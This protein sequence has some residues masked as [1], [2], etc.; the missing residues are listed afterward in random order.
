MRIKIILI[1]LVFMGIIYLCFE[2]KT[3]RTVER[4]EVMEKV[5][6]IAVKDTIIVDTLVVKE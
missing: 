3:D 1:C 5:D 2:N 6:T 4:Q